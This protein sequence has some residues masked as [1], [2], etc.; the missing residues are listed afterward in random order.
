MY[1]R[2]LLMLHN[3]KEINAHF[4]VY[5]RFVDRGDLNALLVD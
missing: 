5:A 1:Y 4:H 3:Q 2:Y